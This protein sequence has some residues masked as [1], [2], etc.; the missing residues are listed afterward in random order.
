MSG[1]ARHR[2]RILLEVMVALTILLMAAMTVGG[3]VIDSVNSM[4][5]T[6]DRMQACDLARSTMAQIEAG[7]VD[8]SAINGPI[9][10][11][12]ESRVLTTM[13][14]GLGLEDGSAFEESNAGAGGAAMMGSGM[15]SDALWAVEVETEPTET[16]GLYLVSVTAWL[17]R[18]GAPDVRQAAYTLRQVVR[19][20]N[21]PDDVAGEED[22]L[23]DAAR[24]GLIG[25]G[26]R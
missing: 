10:R 5:R 21:E 4:M 20:G 23:M 9:P 14:A 11:W 16:R 7:I 2:G 24:R 19:L 26:N 13:D 1:P 18:D 8:P 6:R 17:G 3:I 15:E 25:G 12:D 22:E